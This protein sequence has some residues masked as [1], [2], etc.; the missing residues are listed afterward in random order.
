MKHSINKNNKKEKKEVQAQ[1]AKLEAELDERHNKELAN[2]SLVDA[3]AD[4]S[5]KA[6]RPPNTSENHEE[7]D[8]TTMQQK[9]RIS[10]AQK[11]RVSFTLAF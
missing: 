11:R 3:V 6:E 10:K 4:G 7:E 8:E 9:Q 2:L 1:I 5:G